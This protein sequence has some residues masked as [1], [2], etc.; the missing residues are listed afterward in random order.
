M[1][2]S[3]T[4]LQFLLMVV[5]GWL[6]R[7]Q[8]ALIE[9]L[10]AENRLLRERLGGRRIIFSD[11]ERRGL[12]EKAKAVG[13]KTLRDLGTIVTP[14]TLLRWHRE[15][16]ARKWTFIERRRSGRPRTRQDLV[17][18]VLR[19]AREN[20]GWGY[21]RIQG[22]MANLGHTLGRGTIRRILKEHGIEPAPI[23]GKAVPWSVFL[24]AHW[25]TLV[26]ADFF[27]RGLE[28]ARVDDALRT[29]CHRSRYPTHSHR[30][31]HTPS[32]RCLDDAGRTQ[33]AGRG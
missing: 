6:H 22:A 11:A 8:A 16:V 14:E 32:Q 20:P 24:Q 2:A 3:T 10:S 25:K 27:C 26:G 5:A 13:R 28:L 23:R 18:L 17:A 4:L 12:A 7:Q 9:Y 31:D 33:P 21:T 19:M 30:R 15:L 1:V 29:V